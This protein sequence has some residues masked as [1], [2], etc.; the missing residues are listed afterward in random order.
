MRQ[1]MLAGLALLLSFYC[2][3]QSALEVKKVTF[4]VNDLE[5]SVSFF[6][7]ILSFKTVE[8]Y[9]LNNDLVQYLYGLN[10]SKVFVKIT[11]LKLGDEIIELQ[12]FIDEENVS[13]IP[14]NSKSTDLWFQHIAIVVSDM[15]KAYDIMRNSDIQHVSTSPQTLPEYLPN[16]AGIKAFYFQDID[17]HVLELIYFPKDKGNPK[18]QNT[19]NE[20]FLGIDHTAIGIANTNASTTFYEDV[21]GLKTAGH[22]ENYGSEQERLNQVFGAHLWI[23]GLKAQEGFGVEFLEYL[24]PPGGRPY[25]VNSIPT[26]LWHWHTTIT[27]HDLDLVYE[28]LV[29]GKHQIISNGLVDLNKN[30]F[31]GAKGVM[32]RDPDGHAVLLIED[33]KQ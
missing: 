21:I 24:S 20:I 12:E 3:T 22:S 16:A 14:L 13:Q 8:E 10:S 5:K 33:P 2:Y 1:L 15:D 19:T 31:G 30:L 23:S 18:W 28:K 11:K 27:I 29:T 26:D 6:E 17:R 25:P 9:T 4:T 32:V 7:D